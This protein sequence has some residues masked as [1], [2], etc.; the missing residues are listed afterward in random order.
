M[1]ESS[2]KSLL[3]VASGEIMGAGSALYRFL[4]S[5]IVNVSISAMWAIGTNTN[6]Q[7]LTTGTGAAATDTVLFP[8]FGGSDG[9]TYDGAT[10][11]IGIRDPGLYSVEW[12][13]TATDVAGGESFQ[14]Y[15]NGNSTGTTGAVASGRSQVNYT[16]GLQVQISGIS[17]VI[18]TEADVAAGTDGFANMTLRSVSGASVTLPAIAPANNGLAGVNSSILVRRLA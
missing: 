11:T 8:A 5:L 17:P 18:V 2:L 15:I 9:F 16:D 12:V 1:S 10:G 7:T 14:L 4:K 13:L 3:N 6:A